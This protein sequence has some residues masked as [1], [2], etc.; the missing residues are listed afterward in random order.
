MNQKLRLI[1]KD[2]KWE[3]LND[4][5]CSLEM[6]YNE[7]PEYSMDNIIIHDRIIWDLLEF[8]NKHNANIWKSN[9]HT[10]KRKRNENEGI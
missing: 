6:D 4:F 2:I 1:W 5:Y 3:F 10:K 8:Y 9:G 7:L